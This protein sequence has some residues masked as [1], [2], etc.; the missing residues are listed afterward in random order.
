[1]KWEKKLNM[2][3]FEWLSPNKKLALFLPT[4]IALLSHVGSCLKTVALGYVNSAV[5][6]VLELFLRIS[7]HLMVSIRKR[8]IITAISQRKRET[9]VSLKFY[10]TVQIYTLLVWNFISIRYLE[11]QFFSPDLDS[12]KNL[13]CRSVE[14]KSL[15]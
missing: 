13:F 4:L 14:R 6:Y 11:F 3:Y 9:S 2:S 1:M 7:R 5:W 8:K 15:F 10:H 12:I